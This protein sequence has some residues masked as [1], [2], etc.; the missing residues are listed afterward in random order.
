[1]PEGLRRTLTLHWTNVSGWGRSVAKEVSVTPNLDNVAAHSA[2]VW[3]SKADFLIHADLSE[4][5][6]AGRWEQLWASRVGG[7]RFEVCCL[8]F[9]TYGMALGDTVETQLRPEDQHIVSKVVQKSGRQLLR[10]ALSKQEDLDTLHEA[11]HRKLVEMGCLH[12]W[13]ASGYLSVDISSQ[14]QADE[15]VAFLKPY[16][17]AGRFFYEM[18]G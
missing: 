16:A 2:P 12:E 3:R 7:N 15:L 9:F 6:M 1:M 5:G 13:H 4:A 11:I 8:P 14:S 10:A 18:A 17:E